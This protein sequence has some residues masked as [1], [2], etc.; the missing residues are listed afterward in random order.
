MSEIK[1]ATFMKK[2]SKAINEG[3]AAIFAGAGFSKSAGYV[4]WRTLLKPFAEELNLDI[5]KE[6]NLISLAQFYRNEMQSRNSIN[7]EIVD[8]FS[9]EKELNDNIKIATRL[10]IYTYW[11]TNYDK[12]L[13]EGL[14]YNDRRA[15]V[16][17]TSKQLI[18]HKRD[19]D[20]IVYKMHGDVD[21]A[22]DAVLTKEDYEVY[23][24]NR[25]LFTTVLQGDLV[26]KTFLFVGFSFDD[27][28]LDHIL[29]KTRILS[30]GSIGES[31]WL[32][33]KVSKPNTEDLD[34]LEK[35]VVLDEYNANEIKQKLKI[36]ELQR[37][38]I[39]TVLIKNYDEITSIL[40]QLEEMN[41]RKNIFISGS[42]ESFNSDWDE[43]KVN[44]F[45]TFLSKK[46]VEK[47]YKIHSGFGLGVG[48]NV[49]NGALEEIYSSK[50][51][52]IDEHLLLRPFPQNIIDDDERVKSWR[53]YR[54]GIISEVGISIFIFGNKIDKNNKINLATGMR[55]EF[56]IAK[57]NNNI[58][59][60]VGS[61]GEMA[62]IIYDEVKDNIAD[63]PYLE[64]SMDVLGTSY[65]TLELTNCVLDI[66]NSI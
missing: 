64:S 59:I 1:K 14:R 10:P 58:I 31:Y 15:D 42:M 44:D 32:E 45:C 35:K 21:F 5:E 36:N 39:S 50:Y 65:D 30:G 60:P 33:K 7:Q 61:T 13:E 25:A 2:F 16:K 6:T 48:S 47:N 57:Q 52:H 28:N 56:E 53:R 66:L 3:Y 4:D 19:R 37:Y 17:I 43:K 55:E 34:D 22:E 51:K 46:I 29:S 20:A 11:T 62:K 12:L 27:P 38:G 8:Q 40:A 54:E 49:I 18:S 41:L 63:Y 26:S 23:N 9:Q 24:Q